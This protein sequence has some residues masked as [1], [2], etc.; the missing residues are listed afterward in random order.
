MKQ[1]L[2][3]I[4]LPLALVL[5]LST[6]V[7]DSNQNQNVYQQSYASQSA[8]NFEEEDAPPGNSDYSVVTTFGA[9]DAEVDLLLPSNKV[10]SRY[11]ALQLRKDLL[12][13]LKANP[14]SLALNMALVR[15]FACAPNFSGGSPAAALNYASNIYS[16]NRYVGCLA[17]EY[18]YDRS[19]NYKK[20]EDWYKYSTICYLQPGMEWRE[21]KYF[22]NAPFG[23]V[24]TGSFN[25]GKTQPLYE[26]YYGTL[27]RKIMIPKCATGDCGFKVISAFLKGS[28]D[29]KGELMFTSW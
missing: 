26:N 13:K 5:P 10:Y 3:Q 12:D 4:V 28:T 15:F 6:A 14:R 2:H 18:I 19:N 20:A 17:Y 27:A 11:E 16:V 24:V 7:L 23:A 29:R 22:K 1:L 25:N 8:L 9:V 21:V